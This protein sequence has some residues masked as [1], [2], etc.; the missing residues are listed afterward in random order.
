MPATLS[1]VTIVHPSIGDEDFSMPMIWNMPG[2][3]VTE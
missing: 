2:T 3:F 1:P